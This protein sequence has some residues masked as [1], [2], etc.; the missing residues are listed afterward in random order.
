MQGNVQSR[1]AQARRVL[2]EEREKQRKEEE[3]RVALPYITRGP[4]EP[5]GKERGEAGETPPTP[6]PRQSRDAVTARL[7]RG[8]GH[9]TVYTRA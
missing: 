8:L 1:L 5:K 7:F 3:N 6:T 4:A 9:G 2:T